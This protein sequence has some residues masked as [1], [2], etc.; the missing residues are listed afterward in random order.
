MNLRNRVAFVAGFAIVA[1]LGAPVV[2]NILDTAPVAHHDGDVMANRPSVTIPGKARLNRMVADDKCWR[3]G[4]DRPVP[5]RVWVRESGR[6]GGAIYRLRG[7]RTVSDALEQLFDGTDHD[8]H[9][10]AFCE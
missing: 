1:A 2:Q 8:L 4:T 3:D 5:S 7:Q 9:I 10:I 6:N